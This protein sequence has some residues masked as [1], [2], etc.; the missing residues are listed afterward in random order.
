MMTG[1]GTVAACAVS[2]AENVTN[3][4][5]TQEDKPLKRF[6]KP[7]LPEPVRNP[8]TMGVHPTIWRL[9]GRVGVVQWV[10]ARP[11][12]N[13]IRMKFERS[14]GVLLNVTSLPSYGGIADLG[15]AA[16][17]FVAFLARAKQHIWQVLPLC[18]TGFGNS[19]Y[20]GSSG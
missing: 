1:C 16:H 14:S 19:P 3:A 5:K 6:F 4:N 18:P 13:K 7:S 8:Y 17:E 9:C 11:I 15:P 10:S 20:S 2:Y 12:D